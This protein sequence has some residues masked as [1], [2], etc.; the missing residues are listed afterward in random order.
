MRLARPPRA[1]AASVG[2]E[3]GWSGLGS[4]AADFLL[5]D[6]GGGRVGVGAG[7]GGWC[8]LAEPDVRLADER[9]TLDDMRI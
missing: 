9:V 2:S 5:R 3:W 7:A 6:G 8:S 4:R 1:E